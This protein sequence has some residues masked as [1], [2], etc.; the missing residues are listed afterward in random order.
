[1]R[2]ADGRCEETRRRDCGEIEEAV[3]RRQS[4]DDGDVEGRVRILNRGQNGL[5]ESDSLSGGRVDGG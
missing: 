5:P 2:S 1:M 3:R 4:G